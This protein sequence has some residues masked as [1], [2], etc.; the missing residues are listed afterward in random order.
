MPNLLPP[1]QIADMYNF[2]TNMYE[3]IEIQS[4]T[5]TSNDLINFQSQV[6]LKNFLTLQRMRKKF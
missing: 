3:V 1:A 2:C 4:V 6:G 5:S